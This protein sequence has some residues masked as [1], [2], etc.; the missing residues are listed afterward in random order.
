MRCRDGSGQELHHPSVNQ[1]VFRALSERRKRLLDTRNALGYWVT[2]LLGGVR[3]IP[4]RFIGA[5]F[6]CSLIC[7]V[8]SA[9]S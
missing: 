1:W 7:E 3:S 2:C 6:P 9:L 4:P 5:S 8:A